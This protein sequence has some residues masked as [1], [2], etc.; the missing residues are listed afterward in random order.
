[1]FDLNVTF[2]FPKSLSCLMC[3][4]VRIRGLKTFD[5]L[6]KWCDKSWHGEWDHVECLVQANKTSHVFDFGDVFFSVQKRTMSMRRHFQ[7]S[8]FPY[9]SIDIYWLWEDYCFGW[10]CSKVGKEEFLQ[11]DYVV[12]GC[13]YLCFSFYD[14]I[15]NFDGPTFLDLIMKNFGHQFV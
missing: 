10:F 1:M 8:F 4:G 9:P 5:S 2:C 12:F 3:P 15:L 14:V 13:L 11:D 7:E 6:L